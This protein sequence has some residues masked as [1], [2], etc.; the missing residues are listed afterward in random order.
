MR[1]VPHPSSR[2]EPPAGTTSATRRPS[3]S[4]GRSVYSSTGLP[5]G[6]TD[7]G[8]DCHALI[9]GHSEHWPAVAPSSF[10][11]GA[12]GRPYFPFG[13]TTLAPVWIQN[14]LLRRLTFV[15]LFVAL[16]LVLFWFEPVI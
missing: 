2:I 12:L 13:T 9:R 16:A 4:S 6:A 5:S 11:G 1:P 8:T 15:A 7:T 3:P 14:H 10:G